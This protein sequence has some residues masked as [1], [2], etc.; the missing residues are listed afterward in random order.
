MESVDTSSSHRIY[1]SYLL[2][3]WQ[4][5][6]NGQLVWRASLESVQTG[7][8]YHFATVE[9]LFDFVADELQKRR[10]IC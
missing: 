6:V 7:E 5:H 1:Q 2:R 10:N 8:R 4:E 3:F 9:R